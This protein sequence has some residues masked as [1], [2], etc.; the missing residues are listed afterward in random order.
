MA[1]SRSP[2]MH[3]GLPSAVGS[4]SCR[5]TTPPATTRMSPEASE[6]V[7][8][9]RMASSPPGMK[10]CSTSKVVVV[11]RADAAPNLRKFF[12]AFDLIDLSPAIDGGLGIL[13]LGRVGGL[14]DQRVGEL[15]DRKLIGAVAA[16]EVPGF[17][18]RDVK[19]L[20]DLVE[21]SFLRDVVEQGE[22]DVREP[23]SQGPAGVACPARACGRGSHRSPR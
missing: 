12:G 15:V 3:S 14:G 4:W 6:N 17:R 23:R 22:I 16:V 8:S 2:M 19:L 13:E 11:R 21:A 10:S 18:E 9:V 1:S 5:H 7:V 20:A